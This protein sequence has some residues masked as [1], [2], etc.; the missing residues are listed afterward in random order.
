MPRIP[1]RMVEC[2]VY[3][4]STEQA[5]R[6]GD[7]AGGSGF[8]VHVPSEVSG[9]GHVYA[10]TNKHLI[11]RGFQ[12][13]RLT[14]KYG[15]IE[16]VPTKPDDWI[17]HPKY[18]VAV[19]PIDFSHESFKWWSIGTNDFITEQLLSTYNV[20]LGDDAF[21]V[22]RLVVHEGQQK[23]APIARFGNLS[24][25][26]DPS[27]P[28]RCGD[29][30]QPGFLVECRSLSGFSGSP[31]FVETSQDY[32]DEAAQK[33]VKHR[34]AS[35]SYPLSKHGP[36]G[37]VEHLQAG[38]GW[39]WIKGKFGPW[40]LGIDWGHI[41]LWRPVFSEKSQ[42]SQYVK[43]GHWIEANTGIAC[44]LPAWYILDTLNDEELVKRRREDNR[45]FAKQR[46][47]GSISVNDAA[48]EPSAQQR[49][50]DDFQ[51]ALKTAARKRSSKSSVNSE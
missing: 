30:E 40:L 42:D 5:A 13:L 24:L 28:I 46:K 37:R 44:V 17:R 16:T 51:P 34:G 31:V 18:D 8:L 4:Y 32:E 36:P 48:Q 15:G 22:G 9:L 43:P 1:D 3:L 25:M 49:S 27:E 47:A 29:Y 23:N 12:V 10:V 35:G 2:S 38:G 7:N 39:L 26:V 14:K 21:L 45:E 11:D 20:G 41:P 19:N 6:E 33:V 50:K